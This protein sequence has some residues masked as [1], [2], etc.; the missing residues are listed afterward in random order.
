MICWMKAKAQPPLLVVLSTQARAML[1]RVERGRLTRAG[2]SR[3][4]SVRSDTYPSTPTLRISASW[5]PVLSPMYTRSDPR[6]TVFTMPSSATVANS[7]ASGI[8][9][10]RWP[11][12]ESCS[13]CKL[14]PRSR[15]L[16]AMVRKARPSQATASSS[17]FSFAL[18][19]RMDTSSVKQ[20]CVVATRAGSSWIHSP[21]TGMS[22]RLPTPVSFATYLRRTESLRARRTPLAALFPNRPSGRSATTYVPAYRTSTPR[23]WS[24]RMSSHQTFSSSRTPVLEFSVRLE[25]SAWQERLASPKM[26]RRETPPTWPRSFCPRPRAMLVPTSSAWA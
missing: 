24:I 6:Q 5:A 15:A 21:L 23:V 10:G 19:K 13:G 2:S 25:I 26:V 20:S 22:P 17:C 11:R 3:R 8:E 14:A 1:W 18:G 16:R 7:A 12:Y 4:N 9:R